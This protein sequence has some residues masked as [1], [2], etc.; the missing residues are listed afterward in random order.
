[1]IHATS[2]DDEGVI[3]LMLTTLAWLLVDVCL[4]KVALWLWL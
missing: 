4:L 3:I 2:D 1:M